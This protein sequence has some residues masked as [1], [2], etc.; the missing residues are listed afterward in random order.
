VLINSAVDAFEDLMKRFDDLAR[1]CGGD[2]VLTLSPA[3]AGGYTTPPLKLGVK[4]SSA[5]IHAGRILLE[6]GAGLGITLDDLSDPRLYGERLWYRYVVGF[7]MGRE[8]ELRTLHLVSDATDSAG[9]DVDIIGT[10]RHAVRHLLEQ[11]QR[12]AASRRGRASRFASS[13]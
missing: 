12:L 6:H 3:E 7:I 13:R 5:M 2:D 8:R 9:L 1:I 4:S 11:A 10:S